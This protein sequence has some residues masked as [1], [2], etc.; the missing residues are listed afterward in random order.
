MRL[1][2]GNH[3]PQL[4]VQFASSSSG[5]KVKAILAGTA[6]EINGKLKQQMTKRENYDD[7]EE[8]EEYADDD[9]HIHEN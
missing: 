7:D 6:A 2:D 1:C 8:E 3:L 9:H 5:L 4:L